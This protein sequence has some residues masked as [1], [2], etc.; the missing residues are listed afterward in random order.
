MEPKRLRVGIDVDDVLADFI[1][2]FTRVCHKLFGKP[3]PECRPV[4]WGWSNFGLSKGEIDAAWQYIRETP[5]FWIGVAPRMDARFLAEMP[6]VAKFFITSRFDTAGHAA[7]WQ[8]ARWLELHFAQEYPVVLCSTPKGET[9]RV[10]KLDYFIDDRPENC[11]EVLAALP[12]CKVFLMDSTH[13]RQFVDERIPRV[14]S[15]DEFSELIGR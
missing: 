14:G 2:E 5:N 13:N 4:D 8:T 3:R 15:F 1:P 6:H 7:D 9:A 11:L 10:L 12:S